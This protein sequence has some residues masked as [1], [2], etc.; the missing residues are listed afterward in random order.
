MKEAYSP[1]MTSETVIL[2]IL[3]SSDS[4]CCITA[5][6]LQAGPHREVLPADHTREVN[7]RTRAARLD[8]GHFA[9]L[10][11]KHVWSVSTYF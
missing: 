7:F 11:S 3:N 9:G 10:T 8:V 6:L 1:H 5:S 4:A 2:L